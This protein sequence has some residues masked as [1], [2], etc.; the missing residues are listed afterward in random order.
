MASAVVHVRLTDAVMA[1]LDAAR[2]DV[3]RSVWIKHLVNKGLYGQED[4][5]RLADHER[6]LARLEDMA[7]L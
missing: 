3:P 4:D 7:G 2:G 5:D 1:D 6:R